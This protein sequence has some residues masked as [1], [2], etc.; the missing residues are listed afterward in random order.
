TQ[1]AVFTA[2]ATGT[3][4]KC[5]NACDGKAVVSYSGGTGPYTF[6]W[7]PSLATTFSVTN[8][9]DGIHNVVITDANN[10]TASSTVTLTQPAQL[11]ATTTASNSNCG[12]A[13]GNACANVS[14]GTAP[15]AYM[16][17]NGTATSCNFNIVAGAYSVTVTDA[18]TCSVTA[19]ANINDIAAPTVV[20]TATTPVS[21][22]GGNNGTANTSISGG[23]TPYSIL[24]SGGQTSGNV[25]N[26]NANLHSITVTDAA[27]C[28]S[29]ASVQITQPTQLVSAIQNPVN[30]TCNGLCNGSA[31]MLVNGGTAPYSY[32]WNSGAQT[33][34]MAVSLCAGTYTCV[35]TDNN[36]CTTTKT[37]TITQPQPLVISSFTV[38]DVNCNGQANGAINT[39]VTGGT[40]GYSYSWTP[41]SAGTS[42]N[43]GGLTAGPYGVSVS[44]NNGCT[45]I[46]NYVINEPAALSNITGD[47]AAKC[48]LNNGS[49]SIVNLTGGTAPYQY[50]WNSSPI[51]SG[52]T[53]SAL[54][55]GTYTCII[56]DAHG[57][58][59]TDVVIVPDAASP[60]VDSVIVTKPTCFGFQNGQIQV[61]FHKGTPNFQYN[62]SN[63]IA[64]TTQTVTNIGAGVYTFT[65]TD[66]NGCTVS[67]VVNVTEPPILTLIVNPDPTI[68]YGQTTQIYAQAGGGTPNYTYS[69][70]PGTLSG[71][72]PITVN[73][74]NTTQY[75]VS[76]A[77]SRNCTTSPKVITVNVKP[78]LSALGFSVSACDKD[79][80]TLTPNITSPGAGAPYTYV[81]N[82]GATTNSI[83]VKANTAASPGNYTVT[84]KDGCTIPDGIATFTLNVNP[85]PVG[86]FAADVLQGC[87][88]L[89]VTFTATS[90][91]PG[92]T[93]AWTFGDTQSGTGSPV[94]HT[95]A[96][97]GKFTVNLTITN[98]YNCKRDT[99]KVNYIKV[100]P[101]PI[102]SF[103][104]N[105]NPTSILDPTVSFQN[106]SQ[107]AS[108][109]YWDFGDPTSNGYNSSTLANPEH[110]YEHTGTYYV[111]LVALSNHGCK[112]TA[113][114]PVTI[115][116]DFALY[117]PNA[118]TV[119]DNGKNDIFQPVGVGINEDNYRMDIFDRWGENIFTSNN[120]RKGWDG[121]VK[122]GRLAKQDVYVYKITVYDLMGEKHSFVGHV[123]LLKTN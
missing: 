97:S 37:V 123:T 118:F 31:S 57:C 101:Q 111:Y 36:S 78:Q 32:S 99:Q 113:V 59:K 28:V 8:L 46:G 93:Y 72:G 89:A 63:P 108:S 90:N 112:D 7:S 11:I 62:W 24:W 6:L 29:S 41:A 47:V 70:N 81:W 33:S 38:T 83:K 52:A 34:N 40:P 104:P 30:V 92:D 88:P 73:P 21:C 100:Y 69:W 86:T 53:A 61:F 12:Q 14:G 58:S 13:N 106:T 80:V 94:T 26:L 60:V 75:T 10:C 96:D 16:W 115:T 17:S 54:P 39:N 85:L 103:I 27:G 18:N 25:T 15:L 23:V 91:G 56:T 74:T 121:S 3:N 35:V 44:D 117:I 105:P 66:A 95:Y 1:P 82:T 9:C 114:E 79:S 51:Q 98:I 49:A 48:G 22:Y 102:A 64:Q 76:A 77:D 43:T 71:S 122:G 84:V 119:D 110:S 116:P 109:Y 68:C 65:I 107:G 50:Y 19:I 20:V 2:V 42:G 5:Y 45:V 120:F 87:A 67:S 4:V 55:A